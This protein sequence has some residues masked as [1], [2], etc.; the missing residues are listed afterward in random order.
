MNA[1]IPMLLF[2]S[3]IA[4]GLAPQ[5]A[6]QQTRQL[7]EPIASSRVPVDVSLQGL[8][9]VLALGEAPRRSFEHYPRAW[10]ELVKHGR[11][12]AGGK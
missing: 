6:A 8:G 7:R 11:P 10:D 2:V 5:G 12:K 9:D 1:T 4:T 3:A